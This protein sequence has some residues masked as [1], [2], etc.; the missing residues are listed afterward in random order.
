M[1]Q[2]QQ[3]LRR[4]GIK[5]TPAE[6]NNILELAETAR[7]T[8][9]IAL[10]MKDGMEGRD[11]ASLAWERVYDAINDAAIAHDLPRGDYGFDSDKGEFMDPGSHE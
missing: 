4:T 9:V 7:K 3:G 11:F 8:P 6:K 2:E 1:A 10:S 5:A